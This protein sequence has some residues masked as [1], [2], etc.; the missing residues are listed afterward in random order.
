LQPQQI[1]E[2]GRYQQGKSKTRKKV[3]IQSKKEQ[4]K[5][6]KDTEITT[7]LKSSSKYESLSKHS[8]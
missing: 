4:I 1:Q 8:Q 6:Q 7:K 2:R 3:R 5:K